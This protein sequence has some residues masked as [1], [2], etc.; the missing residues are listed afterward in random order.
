MS[1]VKLLER[2]TPPFHE[3]GCHQSPG[4]A[5]LLSKFSN[6]VRQH[7]ILL[8]HNLQNVPH[9]IVLVPFESRFKSLVFHLLDEKRKENIASGFIRRF[10][11]GPSDGLHDWDNDLADL[12][13]LKGAERT[14]WETPTGASG[15]E[16]WRQEEST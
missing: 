1:G 7:L 4:A 16:G 6:Y 15:W 9:F 5:A 13:S 3:S 14:S 2:E 11:H 10:T 8:L 12:G